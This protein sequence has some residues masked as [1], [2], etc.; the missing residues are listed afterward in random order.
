MQVLFREVRAGPDGSPEIRDAEAD[1]ETLSIGSAA[2]QTLQLLGSAVAPRHAAIRLS[3]KRV[4]LAATRGNV[5][6]VN[7]RDV[8]SAALAAGDEIG[9]GGHRLSLVECQ[10]GFD[11]TLEIRRDET[12]RDSEFEGAFR[13]DLRDTWLSRRSAAWL[14]AGITLMASLAVPLASIYL[15][16]GARRQASRW[17]PTDTAWTSGPLSPAHEQAIGRECGVCHQALFT[18]VRDEAC[19]ECHQPLADHIAATRLALTRFDSPGSCEGCHR[20]HGEPVS[21]LVIREDALCVDCHGEATER[22]G[23]LK[24]DRVTEFSKPPSHPA[25][26]ASL[27]HPPGPEQASD[28]WHVAIQ[29]LATAAERS[30]L[31]FSHEEHLDVSRVTS[32]ATGEVLKCAECHRLSGDGEHFEP[33][34]MANHCASCHDLRFD[35]LAPARVLPHGQPLEVAYKIQEY[36]VRKYTDP[37]AAPRARVRRRLPGTETE[38]EDCTGPPLACAKKR[39]ADE[40]AEQFT[41]IGCVSCHVVADT[42]S[43]VIEERFLV[44]PVRLTGDFFPASRFSHRSHE[45]QKDPKTLKVLTGDAACLSCHAAKESLESSDVLVPDV[46]ACT[47]CHAGPDAREGIRSP[48]VT[49]H[50]YHPERAHERRV[51]VSLQ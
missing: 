31:K 37:A 1:V 5:V 46:D 27:L 22:F 30:N 10:P 49:C 9:I 28:D 23:E 15:E 18:A 42:G 39:A 38:V 14:L 11:L 41:R 34:T 6:R 20:E 26:R 24:R 44:T 17:L 43:P 33:V 32:N 7:G 3:G 8:R 51:E 48:C 50:A 12:V 36:F 19:R 40:I 16:P 4:L 21:D 29:P 47:A 45:I 25:F 13:T 35:P 2:D